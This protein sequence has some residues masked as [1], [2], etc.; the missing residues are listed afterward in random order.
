[1]GCEAHCPVDGSSNGG[2]AHI[3]GST[4]VMKSLKPSRVCPHRAP[5][6]ALYLKKRLLWVGDTAILATLVPG[7]VHSREGKKKAGG[8]NPFVSHP[9]TELTCSLAGDAGIWGV[10]N[11]LS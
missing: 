2:K 1:M 8:L 6:N 4:V 9:I 10:K 7:V 3:A 5:K 11:Y